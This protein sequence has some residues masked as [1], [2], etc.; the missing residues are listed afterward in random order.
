MNLDFNWLEFYNSLILACANDHPCNLKEAYECF[1]RM[2]YEKLMPNLDTIYGITR[3][4]F[5]S[6][7]PNYELAIK[8]YKD[9]MININNGNPNSKI[10][11][12][13][14]KF[15]GERKTFEMV[16]SVKKLIILNKKEK[17]RIEKLKQ[18]QIEKS[19]KVNNQK[20]IN[21]YLKYKRNE[22][23]NL[24]PHLK[25]KKN[26]FNTNKSIIREPYGPSDFVNNRG[27]LKRMFK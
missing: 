26:L 2:L 18:L 14:K 10:L 25:W 17:D 20:K 19:E 16:E 21:E 6:F 3:C 8:I 5:Y 9:N 24:K 27:F 13:F 1:K 15:I 22:S 23:I 7:E 11:K 4:A 12:A